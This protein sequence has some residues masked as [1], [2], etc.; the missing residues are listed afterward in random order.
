MI[1][2]NVMAKLNTVPDTALNYIEEFLDIWTFEWKS[3]EKWKLDSRRIFDI[4]VE[5]V[6]FASKCC[7]QEIV[8]FSIIVIFLF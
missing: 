5:K 8:I 4:K 2:V 3:E 1:K 7:F 6:I